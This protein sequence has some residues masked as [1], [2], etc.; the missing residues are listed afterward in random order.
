[1]L[2]LDKDIFT[3]TNGSSDIASRTNP[4]IEF[5]KTLEK[6]STEINKIDN[7]FFTYEPP[8]KEIELCGTV[9]TDKR[10]DKILHCFS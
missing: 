4:V 5:A 1:M 3:P 7:I 8:L 2:L 9:I 6:P 10:G